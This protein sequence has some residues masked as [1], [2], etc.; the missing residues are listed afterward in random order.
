M[1][2]FLKNYRQSPRKVRVVA[3]IVKGKKVPDALSHLDY[4]AKRAGDPLAK[5]IK[6]AVANAKARDIDTSELVIKDIRVDGGIV[7]RGM[8]PR[9][10]GMGS[11]IKKRTSHVTV[12]LA[13]AAPKVKKIKKSKE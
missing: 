12:E 4:S 1:R 11:P 2:A 9:S 10:R 6:S 7:I 5:L 13:Q 8:R 3:N